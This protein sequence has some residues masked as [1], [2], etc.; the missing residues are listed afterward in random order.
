LSNQVLVV[1]VVIPRGT[2]RFQRDTC[3]VDCGRA[4]GVIPPVLLD[5]SSVGL[6][7]ERWEWWSGDRKPPPKQLVKV[8]VATTRVDYD[9]RVEEIIK[10]ILWK[11]PSAMVMLAANE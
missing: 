1:Q 10:Y 5:D 8:F 4:A 3:P 6:A 9:D 2:R 11:Y 7:D